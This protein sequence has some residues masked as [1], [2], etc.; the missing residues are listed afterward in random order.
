MSNSENQNKQKI[1]MNGDE[2]EEEEEMEDPLKNFNFVTDSVPDIPMFT[3]GKYFE[4]RCDSEQEFR[5][6]INS[7][8]ENG[9][10]LLYLFQEE[11]NKEEAKRSLKELIEKLRNTTKELLSTFQIPNKRLIIQSFYEHVKLKE[12][13]ELIEREFYP[14]VKTI[15][16]EIPTTDEFDSSSLFG[17]FDPN[18]TDGNIDFDTF[19]PIEPPEELD[20]KYEHKERLPEYDKYVSV[21]N[22]IISINTLNKFKDKYE[23]NDSEYSKQEEVLT[24]EALSKL[25]DTKV[26]SARKQLRKIIKSRMKEQ[27]TPDDSTDTSES[28]NKLINK[29]KKDKSRLMKENNKLSQ[30]VI[31]LEKYKQELDDLRDKDANKIYQLENKIDHIE[32]LYNKSKDDIKRLKESLKKLKEYPI[33]VDELNLQLAEKERV[34][35]ELT[36]EIN[37]LKIIPN[38]GEEEEEME[39]PLKNFNFVTDSVPDI[40]MFTFGKYFEKRC[41]SEQEFR[42]TINS[43]EENGNELLYLFQEEPNKEEAKRSLK[44]LIE[45]LRNTTKE[46]LSTFQIPN[47]RLII[48]SFYEHVKLKECQELIEREFYPIVKTI[49]NEIPTTDEFDSS[50]LFGDFDP[51]KTDGNIDFDTFKPIEPPEE[52]DQK[53]EHKERLPEY[54]KYVSVVNTIISINTLNKFKDKYEKNDSE[55]S[56]QEEVLTKEAL[57]KLDD[58]KVQSARKQLRKIIKSRMKEQS[59]PDDSTDT[60]ESVNK[61]INKLKKDKSRLMKENGELSQKI[62]EL[63]A[64]KE[65]DANTIYKLQNEREMFKDKYVKAKEELKKY[66][67]EPKGIEDQLSKAY[68]EM[69]ELQSQ[70]LSKSQEVEELQSQLLSKSQEVEELQNQISDNDNKINKLKSQSEI[71]IKEISELK[72]SNNELTT[73]IQSIEEEM[74]DPLKNF[75]FVTDSVPDIPMFTFGKYF[76]KRCDSEQEFR[77]TINSV[78][79]N[80][81]ELLYLFQ[82]EPNKEEA[83]RSLKELIE[84]LRNTTKELLSTFQIPNKRLIIQSFYEHVKLKE[85]QELIEREFYPIVKTIPNEIPTT[86]EFDSSSLFG[87]FDPNKTDGNIDFDTFKPIEPPEELDQKYEHKERLPEYD[88]YVSVVNTIISINTLNK[89]KDKYEKNDSEYSKQ[90]EVLTK[91]ALSKLDDTKVQS[92]RKQLRKIISSK[93]D[94]KIL[95]E[96][97]NLRN[98]VK[99][100]EELDDKSTELTSKKTE[101]TKTINL[102]TT[103][104]QE[105]TNTINLL[106]TKQ[107]ELTNTINLLTTKQKELN[108]ANDD[109]TKA[110]DVL[111]NKLKEI[112]NA[113]EELNKKNKELTDISTKLKSTKGELTEVINI[114]SDARKGHE[115]TVNHLDGQSGVASE[116]Q[117]IIDLKSEN[118]EL[119]KEIETLNIKVT[120][121]NSQINKLQINGPNIISRD[122]TLSPED[123][124]SH[125]QEQIIQLTKTNSALTEQLKLVQQKN[126]ELQESYKSFS[127]QNQPNNQRIAQLEQENQELRQTIQ[128]QPNNQ[129]L[130]QLK[131]ENQELRQ[132]IQNQPNNQILAQLKQ[133]NQELIQTIQNQPNNQILAQLKQENQE[134]RQTIQNQPNN[135]VLAQLKQENQELRQTIQNQPNNQIL[136][137]LKQE[138]QELRQT[139][140][141]QPN[142]QVLAQL[143]QENQELRQTIQNQPNNQILAQLKQENQELIQTIQNQ[144]NNQILAQLKQENQELRQTIQNQPNNQILAQLKQENQELRQTI[145]NQPNNQRIAQ[146]EQENQELIQTIQNQPNNQIL[147]QLKQENQEL[148]QTIQNQPNNQVLAQLKQENQELRQP[149]QRQKN[150]IDNMR[151]HTNHVNP[152][153]MP[154]M[155]KNVPPKTTSNNVQHQR[156]NK[157]NNNVSQLEQHLNNPH[158][159]QTNERFDGFSREDLI[160]HIIHLENQVASLESRHSCCIIE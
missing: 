25:D 88:K 121:L 128:N 53:Y 98:K 160:R 122:F 127:A 107:Q 106:T 13:Q 50:S 86:D 59:T 90:E 145:Q 66:K 112:T 74:G 97:Q 11:P 125:E 81:N 132:T 34:I 92:A 116:N 45:K 78:E 79:E 156:Q 135:Q 36:N 32:K 144:P 133:E 100:L 63:S 93:P 146:L 67:N 142:N 109:I 6:T 138:N 43:V 54:D 8:E 150:Q 113:S 33:K 119:K 87:D 101:L 153:N 16:N 104:Q 57:S 117:K 5:K 55:Y 39:D 115:N 48:Q 76:E 91:E 140:Q 37:E 111:T 148:R 12:C 120:D 129:I 56:K 21:V 24:K 2:E 114:L 149:I 143:K 68:Q 31:E 38:K 147:A 26:Q 152:Q 136:A 70:L 44:E 41:D 137:Q 61:L 82:E 95:F 157:P 29:L 141:N 159:Q 65:E 52:L 158:Q 96:I 131:Q 10:E 154:G 3:F 89:F 75:N 28:V 69:E 4:K 85:C 51:N 30:Q 77:K 23:K 15:P 151:R 19:K 58:T 49:P 47:K 14:I 42:K 7:V 126:Y 46:L 72:A 35:N 84:K 102:L 17:D 27:S 130:A 110:S 60:S 20:Q 62:T 105:L 155:P 139:I 22:T 80:G 124:K 73:K 123:I 103:K 99:T 94:P 9:N 18:K 118:N 83:K 71:Q 64:S 40:P 108:D 1:A 134:L